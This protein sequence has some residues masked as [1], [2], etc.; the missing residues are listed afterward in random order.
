MTCC[1]RIQINLAFGF[2]AA[3]LEG[4]PVVGL[5]F[6]IS[7]RIGAAMWAHDLEKR[8]HLFATG[9][10]QPSPPP[11]FNHDKPVELDFS[12][13]SPVSTKQ[14]ISGD[15]VGKRTQQIQIGMAGSWQ[16]VETP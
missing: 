14:D 4:L 6:S 9:V 3:L 10:L 8:Q 1:S 2:V 15:S 5:V 12:G 11:S 16:H 13:H 7:N